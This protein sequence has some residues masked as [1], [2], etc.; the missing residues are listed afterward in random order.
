[1]RR[2]GTRY[3]DKFAP[4]GGLSRPARAL[5]PHHHFACERFQMERCQR[6]NDAHAART[7]CLIAGGCDNKGVSR[8][9]AAYAWS[10]RC[11]PR[12]TARNS[13]A[14]FPS[15]P[16]IPLPPTFTSGRRNRHRKQ[17]KDKN[18]PREQFLYPFL[19]LQILDPHAPEPSFYGGLSTEADHI[20]PVAG[21]AGSEGEDGHNE[22]DDFSTA[23]AK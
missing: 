15:R 3:S 14:S 11:P 19:F 17:R 6:Y 9:S 20:V 18:D 22:P 8:Y 1:M 12:P 10:C 2:R 21:A 5:S 13:V 7:L 4:R 16:C 23:L